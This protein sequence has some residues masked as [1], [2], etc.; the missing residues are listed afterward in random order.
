M[1]SGHDPGPPK[2]E[3]RPGYAGPRWA[4]RNQANDVAFILANTDAQGFVGS[5]S[6][7]RLPVERSIVEQV[8]WFREIPPG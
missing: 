6:M 1:G 5:S 7:E 2:G 8:R 3:S 4:H